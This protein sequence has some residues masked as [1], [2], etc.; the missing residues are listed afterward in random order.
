MF[1]FAGWSFIGN[2]GFSVRDQGANILINMFF[3]VAVNAAKGIANQ[4]GTV[5]NGFASNFTM[6]L[7]PQ[8]T[9]RY[10]AG[11]IQSML[12]LVMNGCRYSLLLMSFVVIPIAVAAPA[13]LS[14]WLGTVAPYTVGFLRLVLMMSLVD[15]VVSPIT[16]S[17]Q[18][19]GEIRK[20]QMV[21]SIIMIL[22]LPVAWVLLHLYHNPY[23]VLY[24]AISTSI[25]GLIARLML[26]HEQIRYSY[27]TFFKKV[28]GRTL[29]YLIISGFLAYWSY[30]YF[31]DNLTGMLGYFAFSCTLMLIFASTVALGRQER[32]NVI[33]IIR[34]KIG[35]L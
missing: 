8:I 4:V 31:S 11:N 1:S 10:A 28:Y 19:T 32:K 16:T 30:P 20:F 17:L 14:L 7:T 33:S 21:I 35:K 25:I 15:C 12:D 5:I 2:M 34:S 9:K 3:N 23:I 27:A 22:N 29:F 26:L 24:A 6:A 13:V 18:A